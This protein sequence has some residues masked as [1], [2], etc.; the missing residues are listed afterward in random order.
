MTINMV[1]AFTTLAW[2]TLASITSSQSRHALVIGNSAHEH[3][4]PLVNPK[5]D[6]LADKNLLQTLDLRVVSRADSDLKGM[7]GALRD[8][9]DSLPKE[10]G[11]VVLVFFAGHGLQLNGENYLVPVDAKVERDREVGRPAV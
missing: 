7:K 9:I 8:F 5:N 2:I 3:T 1:R 6:A 4:R 11:T 10:K